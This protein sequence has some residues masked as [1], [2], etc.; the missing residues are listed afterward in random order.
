MALIKPKIAVIEDD[1]AICEMYQLK[2][3]RCGYDVRT[4]ANGEEGLELVKEFQPELILLD[5]RMPK[6]NGDEMLEKMRQEKWGSDTRVIVLTNIS[7]DEAPHN[8]R[9]LGVDR[10]LVKAHHTPAEVI[11]I[12]QEI[13]LTK[14]HQN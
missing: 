4:A 1:F 5:L 12:V 9:L 3:D 6:M 2:L 13:L 11:D 10:Y 8:L 14:N 7:R